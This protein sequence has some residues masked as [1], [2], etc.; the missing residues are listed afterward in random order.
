MFSS[1]DAHHDEELGLN[2]TLPLNVSP[3][4]GFDHWGATRL[5]NNR[6]GASL[7]TCYN[8]SQGLQTLGHES[9]MIH[10]WRKGESPYILREERR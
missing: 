1:S 5:S 9:S 6:H 7:V 8:R 3:D 10:K 4:L 2:V